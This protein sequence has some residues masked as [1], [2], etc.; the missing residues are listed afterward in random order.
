MKLRLPVLGIC[1]TNNYAVGI[2]QVI[3]ANN[4]SRKSIGLILFILAREYLKS[5]DK[6]EEANAL[7]LEDFTGKMEEAV[8]ESVMREESLESISE[9]KPRKKREKSESIEMQASEGV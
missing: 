1:Y 8:E 5:K 3:P 9:E 4:K 2:T 7:K 6:D